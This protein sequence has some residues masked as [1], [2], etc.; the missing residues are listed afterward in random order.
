MGEMHA[1]AL[2]VAARYKEKKKVKS[3][4]GGET[5]VY[6][7]SERQVA[8]RNRKKAE[9]VEKLRKSIDKLRK[10]VTKDLKSKDP[11]TRASAL[12]VG[13]MDHTYERIGN[14]GS[15]KEGHFGVT[16]WKADQVKF[17]GGKATITYVGKSGVK[18]TK[19]VTDRKL[20]KA[21]KDACKDREKNCVV[22]DASA[23]QV[24][25][26]LK[27]FDITAKD[28]RGFHANQ[29]M[30]E[31]L[32]LVRKGKLPEDS[33]EREK[34]LKDEFKKALELAAK[35]VGH[36]PSTLKSQYLVPGLEEDYLK[37][38][39]ISE[40]HSK[41]SFHRVAS[42]GT[43]MEGR[44]YMAA[45]TA[46]TLVAWPVDVWQA[47]APNLFKLAAQ[48]VDM[49][50]DRPRVEGMA[51][52]EH[53]FATLWYEDANGNRLPDTDER[54][55]L[56]RPPGAYMQNSEFP[57]VLHHRVLKLNPD[58]S[59]TQL[60]HG[61]KSWPADLVNAM[62]RSQEWDV[63]DAIMVAAKSCE[64]CLN[65]LLNRYLGQGYNFGSDEYWQAG[66]RCSMCEHIDNSPE[67]E[68]WPKQATKSDAEKEDENVQKMLRKEPKKKPPRYDLRNNRTLE[69]EDED[70]EGLGGGEKGDRDLSLNY[71][72]VAFQWMALPRGPSATR[73]A[74]WKQAQPPA[75]T[76]PKEQKQRTPGEVW[77]TARGNWRGM[78]QQGTQKSFRQR[79]QAENFAKGRHERYGEQIQ[80][81][82]QLKDGDMLAV[83]G[84]SGNWIPVQVLEHT[85]KGVRLQRADPKTG[86]T[87]GKVFNVT[88][89]M[90]KVTDTRMVRPAQEAEPGAPEAPEG[91]EGKKEEA[92][93]ADKYKAKIKALTQERKKLEKARDKLKQ[94]LEGAPDT[95]TEGHQAKIDEHE[96]AIV[97][98]E[99][100]IEELTK[101]K[102]EAGKKAKKLQKQLESAKAKYDE[103]VA[104]GTADSG[105]GQL[106][107][108]ETLSVAKELHQAKKDAVDAKAE[109]DHAK[110]KRRERQKEIKQL[111][112][113]MEEGGDP[114]KLKAQIAEHEEKIKDLDES[115][116]D[117]K[118]FLETQK[119][120]PK[121]EPK[122]PAPAA[123]GQ[124][125]ETPFT[126]PKPKAEAPAGGEPPQPP[127]EPPEDPEE[128]KK[129]ERAERKKKQQQRQ[130]RVREGLREAQE[131]VSDLLGADSNFPSEYKKGIEVAL[132]SLDEDG[133]AKFALALENTLG[134][135]KEVDPGGK[136]ARQIANRA[137]AFEDYDA[138]T[139]PHKLAKRIAEAAWARSVVANP[140]K[141]GGEAVG[142]KEMTEEASLRRKR[143]AF[144]HFRDLHPRLRMLAAKKLNEAIKGLPEKSNRRKELEAL[145]GGASLA[146][147]VETGQE[148]PGRPQPSKGT[149]AL[150]Q[151]LAEQ[152]NIDVMLQGEDDFY[153]RD[154]MTRVKEALETMKPD[155]I[156][157]LVTHGNPKH[158]Y[159]NL[160]KM[161]RSSK[162]PD[163]YR[164]FLGEFLSKT[165]LNDMWGDRLVR[166]GMTL[167]G[168]ADAESPDVRAG[169]MDEA[170][171]GGGRAMERAL[172]AMARASDS[173]SQG[174]QPNPRDE[175]IF[176]R[177]LGPQGLRQ[178]AKNLLGLVTR[179]FKNFV[180]PARAAMQN[181]AE[182]GNEDVLRGDIRPHPDEFHESI[183]ERIPSQEAQQKADE[184][185]GRGDWWRTEADN[186]RAINKRDVPKTFKEE[187]DAERWAHGPPYDR[188]SVEKE[189]AR[190]QKKEEFE[191]AKTQKMKREDLGPAAGDTAEE[192]ARSLKEWAEGKSKPPQSTKLRELQRSLAESGRTEEPSD[193][194]MR[195]RHMLV[196][197]HVADM[198][199]RHG[200]SDANAREY[201]DKLREAVQDTKTWREFVDALAESRKSR[202]PEKS[203]PEAQAKGKSLKDRL[204]KLKRV[205]DEA[206]RRLNKLKPD[207]RKQVE[208]KLKKLDDAISKLERQQ[209]E[210]EP[211]GFS[212]D[213]NIPVEERGPTRFAADPEAAMARRIAFRWSAIRGN[214]SPVRVAHRYHRAS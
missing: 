156:A 99:D 3:Q 120:K 42:E 61:E 189:K 28:I 187:S 101:R 59:S 157:D 155:E 179:K 97:E 170:K 95:D 202:G 149:A 1:L 182:T 30:K 159:A 190:R 74:F 56:W 65:V 109:I 55:A 82:Q 166:D 68:F 183:R 151:K 176:R 174:K 26:Y 210:A 43:S 86:Q 33:K 135:L 39:T 51:F 112:K 50:V 49:P 160:A 214:A 25:A 62:V 146:H 206:K 29:E 193:R 35:A 131:I 12:A 38:G 18:H 197:E 106:L 31:Q 77:Q 175:G 209:A 78:N 200:L 124:Q 201:R 161:V 20:V 32:R 80:S 88:D 130:K 87:S 198:Q 158:P 83:K 13:L 9:R 27:P 184:E 44:I 150:V 7:Y 41:K 116:G 163:S 141:V 128:K 195:L 162:T 122:A 178:S 181:Y 117:Y 11:K 105:Y 180:S 79:A 118:D 111:K 148:L 104:K 16:T 10:Q 48:M 46:P 207:Q 142:G 47:L 100:S 58:G 85:D 168:H 75:A 199:K 92:P 72:R 40:A 110:A 84:K 145:L 24:N 93:K 115:I 194:E 177:L 204:E 6:V 205:R 164:Q 2:R 91:P 54:D 133:Q 5:T 132:D 152:G 127:E 143:Q 119:A 134:Q 22:V 147:I 8:D 167:A 139:D 154:S 90:L 98:L 126:P 52:P 19:E 23:T 188:D 123:P 71:K 171:E 45:Q 4:D 108:Q 103:Q 69:E 36:E 211:E 208:K 113:Q 17:T 73:V 53:M 192:I 102:T 89:D 129:R 14:D 191:A 66:T 121:A 185:H 57:T 137:M 94:K 15:A 153:S 67:A 213:F 64:R 203:K 37:D 125:P 34:K 212:A 63:A 96:D 173:M 136:K 169:V 138:E 172:D 196:D 107:K 140:M 81:G 144:D 76:K 186:W 165:F 21:M 114:E 60:L 70:L